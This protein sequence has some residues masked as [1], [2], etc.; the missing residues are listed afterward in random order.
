M[1]NFQNQNPGLVPLNGP[2]G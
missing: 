1:P 2:P